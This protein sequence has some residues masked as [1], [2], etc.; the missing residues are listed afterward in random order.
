MET[1]ILEQDGCTSDSLPRFF[2]RTSTTPPESLSCGSHSLGGPRASIRHANLHQNVGVTSKEPG[3]SLSGSMPRSLPQIFQAIKAGNLLSLLPP[4]FEAVAQALD[5]RCSAN[6]HSLGPEVCSTIS[7]LA[8]GP[9][10]RK[11]LTNLAE[12]EGHDAVVIVQQDVDGVQSPRTFRQ[13][14]RLQR[15]HHPPGFRSP[16]NK[17]SAHSIPRKSQSLP[18]APFPKSQPCTCSIPKPSISW[19]NSHSGSAHSKGGCREESPG[20]S[21]GG[22]RRETR[23]SNAPVA[24]SCGCLSPSGPEAWHSPTRLPGQE[25]PKLELPMSFVVRRRLCFSTGC[26]ASTDPG[27]KV[28]SRRIIGGCTVAGVIWEAGTGGP[29]FCIFMPECKNGDLLG[30]VRFSTG[31]GRGAGLDT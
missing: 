20:R 8:H 17:R 16:C 31:L 21:V 2:W 25:K 10:T 28:M 23:H 29:A 12:V 7:N 26:V 24:R 22:T 11:E 14:P 4:S 13:Q 6:M 15:H 18:S 27:G 3:R 1:T 9:P 30:E 5:S 19:T